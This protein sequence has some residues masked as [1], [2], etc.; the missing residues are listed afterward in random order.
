MDNIIVNSA[1][2]Y[3]EQSSQF[4][5]NNPHLKE[6]VV[7]MYPVPFSVKKSWKSS[8]NLMLVSNRIFVSRFPQ[9]I[10]LPPRMRKLKKCESRK[11]SGLSLF[12]N[13]VQLLKES[14]LRPIMLALSS[15]KVLKGSWLPVRNIRNPQQLARAVRLDLMYA[16]P[17]GI[18]I[19]SEKA[20]LA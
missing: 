4:L 10:I 17:I 7:D 12:L 1:L 8:G 20:E 9:P 18:I 2:W 16:A 14:T 13:L 11:R 5:V 19:G 3:A 6:G 15:G